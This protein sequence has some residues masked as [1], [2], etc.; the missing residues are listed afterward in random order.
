M[1][2]TLRSWCSFASWVG[3]VLC[4]YGVVLFVEALLAQWA[5]RQNLLPLVVSD[6]CL[7]MLAGIA[8][9]TSHRGRRHRWLRAGIGALV[10]ALPA[11]AA[12][13]SL[14]SSAWIASMPAGTK[15]LAFILTGMV[16]AALPFE[17]A[18]TAERL[19][20]LL[21]L[22]VVALGSFELAGSLPGMTGYYEWYGHREGTALSAAATMLLG[23]A[24]G[25]RAYRTDRP[26]QVRA[27]KH[28]LKITVIAGVILVFI[29][30]SAGM[31]GFGVLA[32]Q[33]EDVLKHGLE[34]SLRNRIDLF[35]HIVSRGT[36][37]AV[38]IAQPVKAL[39]SRGDR[40][41]EGEIGRLI[42]GIA[43]TRGMPAVVVYD[44]AGRPIARHGR[45]VD[46]AEL[47]V[48]LRGSG[49]GSLLWSRDAIMLESRVAVRK[50]G[51]RAGEVLIVVPLPGLVKLLRDYAGLGRTGT[52]FVCAPLGADVQCFPSRTNSA[53][54]VVPRHVDGAPIP[55][56]RALR[57]ETGVMDTRD[58]R[59]KRV[60]AAYAPV[61]DLGLGM[62]VRI[63]KSELYEPLRRRFEVILA[64][65]LVLVFVGIVLLRW[66]IT[67]LVRELMAEIRERR[68]VERDLRM[69]S[70]A[71]E[72]SA[73]MVVIT[74]HNG[75]I[76][77]VN[78]KFANVTGYHH[79]ELVGK[80]PRILQS[81]H[82]LN[83]EYRRLWKTISAG[84]EWRG[85]FQN[86]KKNGDLFWVY[87][88]ISPIRND[89]GVITHYLAVE[90]D[91]T[92]RKQ[93]EERLTYLAHFD[94]LTN[95]PNRVLFC[96]RLQQAMIEAMERKR[97]AALLFLDLDGF[98]T[99]NDSL[100]HEVGDRLLKDVATALTKCVR[101]GDTVARM[102][103]DEFTIVLADIAHV[104]D[105]TLV[106]RKILGAFSQPFRIEDR[107]LV[108]TASIGIALYPFDDDNIDDL[109]KKADVAMYR[110]KERGRNNFQFYTSEMNDRAE[111]RVAL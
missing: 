31:L 89:E 107:K 26:C 35:Q 103:G 69:L 97:L 44:E 106:A 76:E 109:I 23:L 74:D 46:Q 34:A 77:Y 36:D 1:S 90:E 104:D 20:Q 51:A 82:T 81:G 53:P 71:V 16:L 3:L 63:D 37:D 105:A 29:A 54:I 14:L 102:G 13:I 43:K 8:L 86:R 33:S 7:F 75:V 10:I 6:G 111:R 91:V 9:A 4:A 30:L 99:I 101:R 83:E 25:V 62:V 94:G 87:E 68:W 40:N 61:G 57:G 21:S 85:E 18:K 60:L 88:S 70:L 2:K 78:Q 19:M 67:P 24:L 92:A 93:T 38:L 39:L 96:D 15:A 100:G 47:R 28:D 5:G 50:R 79:S 84:G 52:P 22:A 56:A 11:L 59:N 45:Q 27:D 108:V 41:E 110:A 72:Q 17:Q 66:Q 73:S 95:L 49:H 80:T 48:P 65:L 58:H 98:K 55:V 12:I 32:R 42:D 64:L